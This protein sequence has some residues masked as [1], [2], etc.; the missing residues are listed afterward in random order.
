MHSIIMTRHTE[1][2]ARLLQHANDAVAKHVFENGDDNQEYIK[3]KTELE[4]QNI[5]CVEYRYIGTINYGFTINWGARGHSQAYFRVVNLIGS[6]VFNHVGDFHNQ[7]NTITQGD[8]ARL[9]DM[10]DDIAHAA[11]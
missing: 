2:D 9:E 3:L 8:T 5:L 10:L 1:C 4:L 6:E 7:H 11:E